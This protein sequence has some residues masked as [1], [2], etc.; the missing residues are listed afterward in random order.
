MLLTFTFTLTRIKV[1]PLCVLSSSEVDKHVI[2]FFSRK[3]LIRPVLVL[4]THAWVSIHKVAY[5]TAC[6]YVHCTLS[7][8]FVQTCT[9]IRAV[10]ASCD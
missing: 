9:Y 6:L 5:R 4:A 2:V 7:C 3:A 8:T 1:M 10:Q